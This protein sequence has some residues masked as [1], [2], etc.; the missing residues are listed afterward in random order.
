MDAGDKLRTLV[1]PRVKVRCPQSSV[2]R[3]LNLN[4]KENEVQPL[5]QRT[6][7]TLY[8]ETLSAVIITVPQVSTP[9][10]DDPSQTIP[11][12]ITV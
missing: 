5:L 1:R 12:V 3:D 7:R 10:N 2:S 6:A 4:S 11:L 8:S 9:L